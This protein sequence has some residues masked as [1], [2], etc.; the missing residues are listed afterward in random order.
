MVTNAARD[1]YLFLI[2]QKEIYMY[3]M[4]STSYVAKRFL[5][6]LSSLIHWSN[7]LG[8]SHGGK[9]QK[10]V[11]LLAASTHFWSNPPNPTQLRRTEPDRHIIFLLGG[12]FE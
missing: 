2:Y 7:A 12:Y 4:E 9:S 11:V 8:S 6:Q 5:G 1:N 10:V 3:L